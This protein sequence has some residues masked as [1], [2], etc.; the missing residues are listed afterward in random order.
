[1]TQSYSSLRLSTRKFQINTAAFAV[2]AAAAVTPIAAQATPTLPLRPVA[3]AVVQTL[4]NAAGSRIIIN[5]GAV[6]PTPAP[7]PAPSPGASASGS[8]SGSASAAVNPNPIGGFIQSIFQNS[9][10]WFGTPNPNPPPSVPIFTFEPM[11]LIPG[12]LKPLFG[13]LTQNLNV[14]ACVFGLTITVGP[15]GTTTGSMSRGCA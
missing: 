14:E 12:F 3:D 9:L 7:A 6:M 4:G 15:Y 1:M 2:A 13:W 8:A 10:W 11:S 5:R